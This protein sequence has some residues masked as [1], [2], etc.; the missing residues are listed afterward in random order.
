MVVNFWGAQRLIEIGSSPFTKQGCMMAINVEIWEELERERVHFGFRLSHREL[1]F[2]WLKKLQANHPLIRTAFGKTDGHISPES[3]DNRK[4]RS[5]MENTFRLKHGFKGG[6][7]KSNPDVRRYWI[8]VSLN[9]TVQFQ[10]HDCATAYDPS[11]IYSRLFMRCGALLT[12]LVHWGCRIF[13]CW[14]AFL[15]SGHLEYLR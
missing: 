5:E 8:E 3:T 13:G 14:G 2:Q 7:N 15:T 10:L 9:N 6:K 11:K 12:L 4:V 1:P